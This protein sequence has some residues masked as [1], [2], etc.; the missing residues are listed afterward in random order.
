MT[1]GLRDR[2]AQLE[3]YTS[4]LER[5]LQRLTDEP[6]WLIARALERF[7]QLLVEC[8]ADAGDLWLEQQGLALGEVAADVFRRL[9]QAQILDEAAYGRFRRY[10]SASNRIVHDYGAVADADTLRTA[11]QILQ[12]ARALAGS[13]AKA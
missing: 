3:D 2:L 6:D 12:D 5:A 7:I 1:P 11:G 10:V 4:Q 9:H 13:L 8:C